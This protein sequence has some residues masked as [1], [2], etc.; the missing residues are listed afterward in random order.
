MNLRHPLARA[1]GLGSAKEGATHWLWQRITAIGLT[2]LTVWLFFCLPYLLGGYAESR[3][4]LAQP[5]H[6]VLMAL[7][8]LL[9][10]YHLQLGLQVIVED[11]IHTRWLEVTLHILIKMLILIS[12]LTC[13]LALLRIA[14]GN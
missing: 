8:V 1:R 13:M 3:S 9:L 11:Y 7:Y 12:I 10:F 6:A 5:M 4:F 14:L 2:A